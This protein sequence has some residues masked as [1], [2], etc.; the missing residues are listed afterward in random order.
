MRSWAWLDG[1]LDYQAVPERFNMVTALLD[2]HV[3]GGRG[4]APALVTPDRTVSYAELLAEVCRAA[5]ALERLDLQPEQRVALLLPDSPEFVAAFLGAMRAG[6]V[7]LPLAT[8]ARPADHEHALAD[9]GAVALVAHRRLLPLLEPLLGRL[10][11]LR[12][13]LVV[14]GEWPGGVSFE[15]ALAAEPVRH[16]PASTHRDDMAYWLYSSGTTGRPKAVIHLHHDMLFCIAPYAREA[17]ELTAEDRTFALPR[18]SF[19]YGLG[20]SLYLPLLSGAS[21]VLVAER[22]SPAET[23]ALLPR[24]APTVF[25]AVPTSFAAL[26]REGGDGRLDLGRVRIS[27]SAGEALPES[28]HARWTARTGVECLD[29]LGATEVGFIFIS[30]RPGAVRPGTSGRLLSG[31]RARVVDGE[32]SDLPAGEVGELWVAGE[33]LAPGYFR[34]HVRTRRAFV[35]EWYRT[36]DRYRVDADGYYTSEG[37]TDDLLRVSGYWVSPLEVEACLLEH[38]AVAECAVAAGIDADGLQKPRAFVVTRP[39]VKAAGRVEAL[40]AHARERLAPYKAPRWIRLVDDLPRTSTGKLQR[41]LLRD[42][43]SPAAASPA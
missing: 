15:T 41:Y 8:A 26:L 18:L 7:P 34:Q 36:G 39:G 2:R 13:V 11:G 29:G 20:A 1:P 32:G 42:P 21:T 38:P 4:A 37:R 30:N 16:E 40:T 17:L 14:G 9:S 12:H 35:G 25:F 43:G 10:P 19:S 24:L 28:L 3:Q 22:P 31:Y 33:S 6:L 23:L 27:V 5:G